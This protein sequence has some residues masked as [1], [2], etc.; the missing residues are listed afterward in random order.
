MEG[1][2]IFYFKSGNRYEGD[3]KNDGFE[4]KGIFYFKSGNRYEGDFK[5][6]KFEG[7]RNI[8]L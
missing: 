8:L 6:D 3:F 7:K 1:K 2:G 4:G 5:N